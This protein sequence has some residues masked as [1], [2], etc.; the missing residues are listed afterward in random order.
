MTTEFPH[1]L[2]RFPDQA[3]LVA[4]LANEDNAFRALCEDYSL[5]SE[6]LV[7]LRGHRRLPKELQENAL[8]EYGIFLAELELDIADALASGPP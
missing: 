6:T 2:R 7:E 5:V 4:K 8:H 1:V 3:E